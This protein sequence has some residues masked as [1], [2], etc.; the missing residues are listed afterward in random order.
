M[1]NQDIFYQSTCVVL[2]P[3]VKLGA[4]DPLIT[5]FRWL[6][7]CYTDPDSGLRQ[8]PAYESAVDL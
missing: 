7:F 5:L 8:Y 6:Y 4:D 1:S 3:T 2:I